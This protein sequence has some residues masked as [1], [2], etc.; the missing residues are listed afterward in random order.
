MFFLL[1]CCKRYLICSFQFHA[2]DFSGTDLIIFEML[3]KMP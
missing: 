2:I 3:T 1:L